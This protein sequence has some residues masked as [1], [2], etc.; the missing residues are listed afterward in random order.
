MHFFIEAASIKSSKTSS[1][2]SRPNNKYVSVTK[3]RRYDIITVLY[4]HSYF[5]E[6]CLLRTAFKRT[7]MVAVRRQV[8]NLSDK[9]VRRARAREVRD[10]EYALV[11]DVV[12]V[13]LSSVFSTFPF[14]NTSACFSPAGFL[15]AAQLRSCRRH[16]LVRATY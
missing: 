12:M 16:L 14:L 6:F 2:T 8:R 7:A 3:V 15:F 13:R 9:N 5:R 1:R 4:L 10:A 11:Q